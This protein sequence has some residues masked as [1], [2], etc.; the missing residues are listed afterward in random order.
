[1][2][3]KEDAAYQIAWA[4]QTSDGFEVAGNA[5]QASACVATLRDK[6]AVAIT[7]SRYGVWV[8]VADL[9]AVATN[10]KPRT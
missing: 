4:S 2:T 7:V 1:M 9:P 3:D 8:N 6:G 5:T 10:E